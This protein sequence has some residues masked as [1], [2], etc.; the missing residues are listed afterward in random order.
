MWINK[1]N[2]LY[3]IA[4]HKMHHLTIRK[5]TPDQLRRRR[6]VVTSTSRLLHV[7]TRA[8]ARPTTSRPTTSRPTTSRPTTSRPTTSRLHS[9]HV[10]RV[11]VASSSG[12][13]RYYIAPK[14]PT[15][16]LPNVDSLSAQRRLNVD[17]ST[18]RR[19][20][21]CSN[22]VTTAW[23]YNEKASLNVCREVY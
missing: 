11:Y 7:H 21:L 14:A 5:I 6:S 23:L 3:K 1:W 10:S 18:Q 9:V 20:R 17:T 4:L 8:T 2:E 13:C 12:P 16:R 19:Q 15:S 22:I